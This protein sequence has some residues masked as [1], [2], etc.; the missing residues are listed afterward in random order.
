LIVANHNG[1]QLSLD[2]T[3]LPWLIVF[4]ILGVLFFSSIFLTIGACVSELKEAQSLLLP[5]WL[6]LASPLMVWFVAVR[7]PNGVVASSLS[8]F[9]PSAPLMMSL[10]L[11]SGQT[12]PV[13]HAPLAAMLMLAATALV[14]LVAAR[15][16]RV[17]LLRTDSAASIKQIMKRLSTASA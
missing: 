1:W 4:Q 2:W 14:V 6:L 3:Q 7:D 15:L 8:F 11:S 17:S 13:W 12:M 5:V 16:Y 9:P 10:R